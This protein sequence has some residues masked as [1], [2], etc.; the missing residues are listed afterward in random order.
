MSS[1]SAE[2]TKSLFVTMIITKKQIDWAPFLPK[3][4]LRQD[5]FQSQSTT[6]TTSNHPAFP[7]T[8]NNTPPSSST[9]IIIH[10]REDFH[11]TCESPKAPFLTLMAGRSKGA[12]GENERPFPL[13]LPLPSRTRRTCLA[14]RKTLCLLQLLLQKP[15]S[16]L[17]KI[18]KSYY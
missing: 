11:G 7:S 10:I 13:H 2:R 15:N 17:P 9:P 14:V 5:I 3:S 1:L 12:E 6:T 18:H 4:L 16:M 8:T